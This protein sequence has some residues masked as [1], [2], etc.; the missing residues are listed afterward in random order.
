MDNKCA[1][2][3]LAIF[4]YG[5]IMLVFSTSSALSNNFQV[6][7]ADNCD[8]TSICNNTPGLD[9]QINNCNQNSFCDNF[10]DGTNSQI[11]NC[12]V[13]S[14]CANSAIGTSNNLNINCNVSACASDA[15]GDSNTQ[16][17]ICTG[18]SACANS[19]HGNS[20]TQK[21]VCIHGSSCAS[22]TDGSNS[23]QHT[24]CQSST[25]NNIGINTRVIS[26]SATAPC[27]S[28]GPDTTTI[29]QK[30]RSFVLPPTSKTH[31]P[32]MFAKVRVVDY[33]RS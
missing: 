21:A 18:S 13:G 16:N 4:V 19:A 2:S 26:I 24:V 32:S 7:A 25:C 6:Y 30:N 31:V 20:N 15:E 23:N 28:N 9:T 17:A 29:C 8:A 33:L 12:N 10:A 14:A 27:E 1:L 3:F 5:R 11:N 22:S